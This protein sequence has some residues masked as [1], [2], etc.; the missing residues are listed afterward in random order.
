[1]QKSSVFKN[2]N[3]YLLYIPL[4]K[5]K[6]NITTAIVIEENQAATSIFYM[7]ILFKHYVSYY[8]KDFPQANQ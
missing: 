4:N 8:L 6:K 2:S 7:W 1:M 5:K 3:S